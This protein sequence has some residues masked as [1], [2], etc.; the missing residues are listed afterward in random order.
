MRSRL[1]LLLV[2]CGATRAVAAG[3][4]AALAMQVPAPPVDGMS[5]AALLDQ[6]RIVSSIYLQFERRL[7]LERSALTQAPLSAPS[8]SGT[9]SP[10]VL[11]AVR[12]YQTYRTQN[13]G[14]DDPV[15]VLG[16]RTE[17]MIQRFDLLREQSGKQSVADHDPI[18]EEL[19]AW[20]ALFR[21]WQTRRRPLI[22]KADREIAATEGAGPIRDA[23]NAA[24][25][26]A[27]RL[28]MLKEIGLQ[29]SITRMAVE[30]VMNH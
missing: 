8:E 16:A 11:A 4:L 10:A 17:W 27:Y 12:G 29:F 2:L 30:R 1:L 7:Q 6:G 28:S 21:D 24:A 15:R 25:I 22:E 19:K 23:G 9:D 26:R 5:A 18:K 20:N 14:I 3:S 13:S